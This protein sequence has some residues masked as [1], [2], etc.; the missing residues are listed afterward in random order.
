MKKAKT[1]KVA[2]FLIVSYLCANTV[3]AYS[4]QK[5]VTFQLNEKTVSIS[6]KQLGLKIFKIGETIIPIIDHRKV[7]EFLMKNFSDN[8]VK[9]SPATYFFD[10]NGNIQIS[11]SKPGKTINRATLFK[12][13]EAYLKI[14][15]T[16]P[17]PLP[18]EEL[19]APITK[20]DLEKDLPKMQE[21]LNF[22]FTFVDPVYSDN[23][24]IKLKAHPNW[25]NFEEEEIITNL[26]PPKKETKIVIR[27]NPEEFN[28]YIDEEISK[29]LDSE[30]TEVNIYQDENNKII[31]EG[32]GHDYKKIDREL[33][34]KAFELAIKNQIKN[35]PIPVVQTPPQLNI[36]QDLQNMGIKEQFSVGHTSYYGSPYNRIHNI[37]AGAAKLNGTLIAPGETFSF[38]STLG[39]VD[40][41][42]GYR[43]ELV[44]KP[45]GTIPEYGGGLCQVSTTVY[46]SAL[47]GG[48]PIAERNQHSYAVSYYSQILGHGLDATIYI[49]G[50]D[51]KFTNDT[52]HHL[53]MHAYTVNDYELYIVLYGTKDNRSVEMDGPYISSHTSPG[54]PVYVK[55]D[56]LDPGV[57]KQT[58]RAHAGFNV[59]WYRYLSKPGE[60]IIKEEIQTSYKAMPAKIL[61]GE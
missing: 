4:P 28:L 7:D 39:P 31:I 15:S 52:G 53:L 29:W 20:E 27:I 14:E 40:D 25:V 50:A 1:L 61:V 26:V 38:N 47:L 23:W 2:I 46:R 17:I 54:A 57:Q 9:P 32:Q 13:L 21:L 33:F 58:E 48:L 5:I 19:K 59:L 43:K 11:E 3:F 16:T 44:I 41:T 60:E 35:I 18:L 51:L 6:Q 30:K 8:E 49:G 55:T 42:T 45:E 24:E 56:T 37:K 12:Q 36:S 22:S 10:N 34:V